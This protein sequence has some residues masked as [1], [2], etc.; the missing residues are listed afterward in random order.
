[1]IYLS[2]QRGFFQFEELI[3]ILATKSTKIFKS[4]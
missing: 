4:G 2:F 1:M 3:F